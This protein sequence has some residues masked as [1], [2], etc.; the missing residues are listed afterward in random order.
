MSGMLSNIAFAGFAALG[1]VYYQLWIPNQDIVL[2]YGLTLVTVSASIVT[3]PMTPLYYIYTL[4]VKKKFPCIITIL[5]GIFNVTG[6]FILIRYTS[7]GI[8]AVVWTTTV[9]MLVIN[10]VTNPL[11]MSYV[12]KLP[13]GTF[14]PSLFRNLGSCIMIVVVF[15][16]LSKI[17]TPYTWY[18]LIL[19][20]LLYS[21]IGALLHFAVVCNNE[22][23]KKIYRL[24]QKKLLKKP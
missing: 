1:M 13:W 10:F 9:V 20:A 6:M 4:T 16:L 5:G 14:Y 17:Y 2:I 12:L 23:K 11:Y 21:L 15:R 19:C 7:M 8:Y 24:L 3:G 18:G 22:E